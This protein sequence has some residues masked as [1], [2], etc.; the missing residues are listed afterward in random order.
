MFVVARQ[1]R[2][3]ISERVDQTSPMTQ[4]GPITNDS[5]PR[6]STPQ[7]PNP[8][9]PQLH[10]TPTPNTHPPNQEE[11]PPFSVQSYL[12]MCRGRSRQAQRQDLT[13]GQHLHT[14]GILQPQRNPEPERG[15][16]QD[17]PERL[18]TYQHWPHGLSRPLTP[19]P[20]DPRAVPADELDVYWEKNGELHRR[21]RHS[22]KDHSHDYFSNPP[23]QLARQ[24]HADDGKP[25]G[26]RTPDYKPCPQPCDFTKDHPSIIT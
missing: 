13:W 24:K 19:T 18:K 17:R 21:T 16:T 26:S 23:T 20:P 1:T 22:Q 6:Q 10:P 4:P 12:D 7:C 25:A 11:L 5:I 9:P 14:S 8:T 2:F 15:A 3:R